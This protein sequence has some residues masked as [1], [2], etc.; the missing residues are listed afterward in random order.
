MTRP[1]VL[2]LA[3]TAWAAPHRAAAQSAPASRSDSTFR[4]AGRPGPGTPA[5]FGQASDQG[6]T[7]FLKVTRVF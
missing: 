7:L 5:A 1:L 4:G 2:A 6:N 3:L